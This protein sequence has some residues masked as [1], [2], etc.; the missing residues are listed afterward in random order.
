MFFCMITGSYQRSALHMCKTFLHPYAAVCFKSFR[1]DVFFY[2]HIGSSRLQIL[3]NSHDSTAGARKSSIVSRISSRV[4]PKP[5]IM[6]DL[7]QFPTLQ[8]DALHLKTC[9]KLP[10]CVSLLSNALPSPNYAEITS[11]FASIICPI[12]SDLP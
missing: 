9:R 10:C 5:S 8:P 1:S 6:P 11:G 12:N 3:A 4:S 2:F 7:L